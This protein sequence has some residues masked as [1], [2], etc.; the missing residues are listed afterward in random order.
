MGQYYIAV[1]LNR[2]NDNPAR[3]FDPYDY[4]QGGAK[5]TEHSYIGNHFCNAVENSLTGNPGR[6]VWAGDY[7]DNEKG[8]DLN[9]N[10]I[11]DRFPKGRRAKK[12]NKN[13]LP[14][15]MLVV[16]HSKQLFYDRDSIR[17]FSDDFTPMNP[18]PILTAEGNGGGG[19]DYYGKEGASLVGT[20]ARDLI[21]VMPE[22]PYGYTEICPFF[23]DR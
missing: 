3:F 20:W 22:A 23:A 19:G 11:C 6:L 1:I 17:P 18:L 10:D 13:D 7:A 16:N 4:Q 9:L 14:P 12:A 15:G 5:L 8:Q 21:E 2:T